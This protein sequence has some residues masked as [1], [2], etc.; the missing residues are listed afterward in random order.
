MRYK[1]KT[2]GIS[3]VVAVGL[4][5]GACMDFLYAATPGNASASFLKFT[6][7]PRGS[8]MGEAYTSVVQDAY[9][10]FWNPAGLASIESPELAAT[11]INSFEDVSYQ[12]FCGV[13]PLKYGSTL[14]MNI[15]RL[16]VAPFQGYDAKGFKTSDI[17]A[18]DL[19]IGIAYGKV[20]LKDEIERPILNIGANVKMI[21]E[22]L[23]NVSANTFAIDF[24]SIYHIRPNNYW[25]KNIP[26]QE[27]RIG[28]AL[29]NLGPDLKFD[30]TAFPLPMSAT[31]GVSWLS[32]PRG[33]SNLILSMDQTYSNDEKYYT[34]FG[35]EYEAFQLLAFRTGYRTGQ[36]I[37]S[38]IRFGFGLKLSFID[39]DYSMSPFGEL[40]A[41]NKF[42]ISMRFG[43]QKSAQPLAGEIS[44]VEKAKLIAPKK[45]IEKLEIYTKDLL[46]LAFIELKNKKY[47]SAHEHIKKA[48]N[49]KP[50]LQKGEWGNR[51][52]RLNEIIEGLGLKYTP[53]KEKIFAGNNQQIAIAHEAIMAYIDGHNLKALLLSHAAMGTNLRGDAVFEKLLNTLSKL[54]KTPVRPDEILPKKTLIN[55]KLS[56]ASEAFYAKKFDI[57][58]KQCEEEYF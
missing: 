58:I 3:V 8:A 30:K 19:A 34:S 38:G 20:I 36:D 51:E 56:K 1:L 22:K 24:G 23:D 47:V 5:F 31:L 27:W 54:T 2:T 50:K 16:S 33:E 44:R 41:M 17:S 53:H 14:G 43:N 28:F 9:S 15:T 11:H 6:P 21:S 46:V 32:H 4:L 12:Y 35:A 7:S 52:K 39:I 26:A 29:R 49:L 13:Y 45:S 25:L 48:F 18:S 42:G 57:T 10:A 40:G 37:G 55:K